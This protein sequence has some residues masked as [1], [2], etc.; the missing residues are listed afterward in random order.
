M[1][2]KRALGTPRLSAAALAGF[3]GSVW[4]TPSRAQLPDLAEATAQYM[5]GV[6]LED[7]RPARAQVTSYDASFNLPLPLAEK[8]FLIPGLAYHVESVSF[9]NTPSGFTDLRAFH[10]LDVALLYV[11][12]LP[13]DWSL[14]LRVAPGIAGDLQGFDSGLWRI[15]AL[16]LATH[17]FS[18]QF[19]LGGGGMV[20]FSFGTLLPLPAAYVDWRPY[21][22]FQVEAFVPAFAQTKYTFGDRVEVGFRADVAGNSYAIRDERIAGVWPCAA[23]TTD[24][25]ATPP[26][27]TVAQPEQ[28]FDHVA[29]SVATAGPIVGVRLLESL[30]LTVYGGHSFFR[31]FEQLNA[32]D[33]RIAGGLQNLPNTFFVRAGVTWR[34]P[35]D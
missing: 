24:D 22:E 5:P 2:L 30:W 19:V 7:P 3:L 11:Q 17:S 4:A 33:E 8:S 6:E 20:T 29:Y 15:N 25:P 18:D 9:A 10:S 31:R 13:K 23:A 12:L 27:E 26:N 21:P 35:R 14:A 32:D 1:R 16:A 34:L 28:C